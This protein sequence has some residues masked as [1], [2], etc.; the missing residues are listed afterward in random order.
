MGQVTPL[1]KKNDEFRK[2]NYRP[3]TVLTALNNIYERLLVP[4]LGDFYQSILSDFI[5]S[6]RK[7]HSCETALLKLTKD[8]RAMLD[9]GELVTVVS[10]D[11]SKAF[12]VIDHDLLLAKLKA[13]GVGERCF[14]LFKGYLSGRQQ[15]VKIGDTFSSWKGVIRGVPQGSVLGPVFFNIFINDLFYWVTQ[16]KLHA[17]ADDHQFYSSNI[18]P[19]ALE[20][21]ICREVRVA[22]E[23]Y[24][25]N[26]MIV[27]ETKHQAIFLRRTGHSS[28]A[29]KTF[30]DIFGINID[31][32]LCFD[33]Y[34]STI[35]K[36]TNSHF[37]VM[38]RFR[39][40]ISKDT[41]LTSYKAFIMPHFNYCSSV[42]PFCG[43]HQDLSCRIIILHMTLYLVK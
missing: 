8:W 20:D 1:F 33:N 37:N 35:C 16:C 12:D 18:D 4:Q 43:T 32:R 5:S 31:N 22:N 10:M 38:L 3:V 39:K 27:N 6:Y 9:K 14:V 41:L 40:L 19:V 36:K 42:W 7:F 2:E 24:R 11:L 15:R 17:Y 21:C 30:L 13:H 28:F 23:W 29:I 26:R 34:I 25:S